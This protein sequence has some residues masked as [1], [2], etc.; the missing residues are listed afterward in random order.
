MFSRKVLD[1]VII[2]IMLAIALAVYGFMST[3]AVGQDSHHHHPPQDAQLHEKFYSTWMRPDN[4]Q[5]SC[6]HREDCYPAE[7]KHENGTWYAKRREDGKWLSIPE[8]KIERKKDMPDQ[9]SHLCAPPPGKSWY[10]ENH[11]FCFGYS[12]GI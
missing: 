3:R 12:S 8:E 9:R 2:G 10:P 6:C 11:V 1:R 7:A 4:P 5:I